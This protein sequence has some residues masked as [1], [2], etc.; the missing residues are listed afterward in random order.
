MW[1]TI[2]SRFSTH[3]LP[4]SLF[5]P[6]EGI[7]KPEVAWNGFNGRLVGPFDKLNLLVF[8]VYS[9]ATSV[10]GDFAWGPTTIIHQIHGL[11]LVEANSSFY[12]K[13][14]TTGRVQFLFFRG[15]LL[16]LAEYSCRW[17]DWALGNNSMKFWD[18]A[19]IS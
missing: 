3:F 14:R 7:R 11:Y 16:V 4:W 1:L 17:G 15:F 18:F 12:G 6:T 2:L 19:G 5:K 9:R 13:W 10:A 8:T